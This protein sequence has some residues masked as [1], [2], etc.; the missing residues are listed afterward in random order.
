MNRT[1]P[2]Q[3]VIFDLDGTLIDSA[4]GILYGFKSTLKRA[5]IKPLGPISKSLIGPPLRHTLAT[6]TGINEDAELDVLI[7]FFK[8]SY[9][10]D[11]YQ[12]TRVYDGVEELLAFLA[13]KHIPMAIATNKRKVPTLKILEFLGWESYFRETGTLDSTTPP[14]PDKAVLIGTLL[15]KLGVAAATSAYIGD[16]RGDGEAAEANQMPFIAVGWGYGT[17]R[18]EDMKDGWHYAGSPD[19]IS[20]RFSK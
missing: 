7:E 1:L 4:P 11:G 13:N 6:L 20:L 3:A 18:I 12:T 17:W 16:T 10:S 2:F 14:Y 5:G 8:D 15:N 9:D 19:S